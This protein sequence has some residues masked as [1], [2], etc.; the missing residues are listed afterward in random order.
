[1]SFGPSSPVTGASQSDLTSPTY[2]LTADVGPNA[3]SEQ[4]AVTALGGTQTD[5]EA[6]SVSQPFT[7][8]MERPSQFRQLGVPN[9]VTGVVGSV[10]RNKFVVRTRKG[11]LPLAGQAAQ[12]MVIETSISVPAGSDTADPNSLQAALSA[13]FG[14]L[15]DDSA[16]IGDT[17]IDGVL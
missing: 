7:I 2:T 1:M 3:H 16:G 17:C 8:T 13:H 6:H 9:P 12:T 14:V 11:V 4:Y 15:W 5:V 10:P